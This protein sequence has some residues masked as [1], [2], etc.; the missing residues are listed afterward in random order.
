MKFTETEI[1]FI[2]RSA[3][4]F[5]NQEILKRSYVYWGTEDLIPFTI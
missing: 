4:L 1:C 3:I 5:S 2:R